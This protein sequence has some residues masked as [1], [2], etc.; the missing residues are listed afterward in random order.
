MVSIHMVSVSSRYRF[1]PI[2]RTQNS[3][4]GPIKTAA[5]VAGRLGVA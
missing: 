1:L 4:V 2:V 3:I 5:K